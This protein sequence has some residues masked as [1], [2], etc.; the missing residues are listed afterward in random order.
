MERT[1]HL[2]RIMKAEQQMQERVDIHLKEKKIIQWSQ[3][4][5]KLF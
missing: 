3:N 5:I 1:V 2:R 4:V